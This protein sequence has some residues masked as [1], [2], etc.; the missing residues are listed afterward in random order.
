MAYQQ[1][2]RGPGRKQNSVAFAVSI[3]LHLLVIWI[4]S[5]EF[6]LFEQEPDRPF[7]VALM[8]VEPAQ[9]AVDIVPQTDP[10]PPASDEAHESHQ[11][12]ERRS[13][14]VTSRETASVD[15]A[16]VVQKK[17]K[18]AGQVAARRVEQRP[19]RAAEPARKRVVDDPESRALPEDGEVPAQSAQKPSMAES[20]RSLAA[21]DSESEDKKKKKYSGKYQGWEAVEKFPARVRRALLSRSSFVTPET[22]LEISE[23]KREIFHRYFVG[24][25]ANSIHPIFAEKFLRSLNDRPGRDPI[26]NA[27]LRM[28]AEFEI[29]KD[30]T[31]GRVRVVRP[32]GNWEF[33]AGAVDA[34]YKASPFSKPPKAIFSWNKRVYTKWGFFR[35]HR[36][37]GVFNAQPYI[38]EKPKK[39]RTIAALGS[40]NRLVLLW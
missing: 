21:A 24:V 17:E 38:L 12:V 1:P 9:G 25:H 30:G 2:R 27:N 32:S 40:T 5:L 8:E 14:E 36:K 10:L 11:D 3:F 18:A 29:A 39:W 20:T 19:V 22:M 13:V 26:N 4:I 31:V 28:Y 34:L 6:N 16:P 33:D 15:L 7:E 35:N 37:C 23:R